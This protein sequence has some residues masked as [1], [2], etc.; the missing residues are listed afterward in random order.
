MVSFITFFTASLAILGASAA[1]GRGKPTPVMATVAGAATPLPSPSPH[2]ALKAVAL[3]RGTQN[4]TC[5]TPGSTAAPVQ[6]GALATL[7]DASLLADNYMTIFNWLPSMVV[8]LPADAKADL[9]GG[10]LSKIGTH[11]FDSTGAPTFDLCRTGFLR[12][13]KK[14]NVAAPAGAAVGPAGTGAVDWL[15]LADAGGSKG[16]S[17]GYRI[18]TAGGKPPATCANVNTTNIEIPYAAQ[19]WFW[20]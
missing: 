9:P 8:D 2:L 16:L 7:Y 13:A 6:V 19:Y 17:Q 18:V 12:A 11:Y 3:G 20:G 4:Y 14:A 5:A 10:I 1:P 15:F